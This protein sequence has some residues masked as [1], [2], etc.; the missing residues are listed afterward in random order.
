MTKG[1]AGRR[2]GCRKAMG[3]AGMRWDV[4]EK[5]LRSSVLRYGYR[6]Y[7]W[8]AE[9]RRAILRRSGLPRVG[10]D[11]VV[12]YAEMATGRLDGGEVTGVTVCNEEAVGFGFF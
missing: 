1:L 9:E 6:D 2:K 3:C 7:V 5:T 4:R 12:D 10:L 8:L 11:V